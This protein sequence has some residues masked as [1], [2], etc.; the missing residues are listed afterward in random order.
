MRSRRPAMDTDQLVEWFYNQKRVTENNC[1]EWT[2]C[3]NGG[4]GRLSI[5]GRRLLVHRYSLELHLKREIP[6]ELEVRHMCN[7]PICF[8]PEHLEEGT[9]YQNMKDMVNSNRQAKGD[10]LSK[11]LKGVK[12]IASNGE[13][14][15][16]VKLTEEQV[17][18][19]LAHKGL[20]G[21]Q[22]RLSREYGVSRKQVE[23]IQ[24]GKSWKHLTGINE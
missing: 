13:G 6:K 22:V 10:Y 17:L 5:N 8:N 15:S 21:S 4:Y 16:N 20:R 12:H 14:N 11:H 9:H 1:W 23:R 24:N 18:N 3:V 19:I 2:R 7:N